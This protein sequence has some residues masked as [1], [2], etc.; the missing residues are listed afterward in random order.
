VDV[1]K[2]LQERNAAFEVIP[3]P[4]AK[5]SARLAEAVH[6]P[7]RAV[8]KSVLLHANHG[9]VD[10]VAVV[11]ADRKVNVEE[12]SK[13]LGGAEVVVGNEDDVTIRCPDCER[14]VLPPFGS[15][16][17]MQTIVD[18]SFAERDEFIIESNTHGEAI[19]LKW[20]DFDRIEN[21][22]VGPIATSTN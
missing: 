21:P 4:W 13:M 10:V 19:R 8:A 3:H 16:Y 2:F 6:V 11:P 17:N 20:Q 7:G 5:G 1:K 18:A 14:G 9:F 22:L 12:V 15:Q